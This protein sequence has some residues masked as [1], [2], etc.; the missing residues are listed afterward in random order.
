MQG[1]EEHLETVISAPLAL[2]GQPAF[3]LFYSHSPRLL[4]ATITNFYSGTLLEPRFVRPLTEPREEFRPRLTRRQDGREREELTQG[5]G[6]LDRAAHGVQTAP[7]ES[8]QDA[9]RKGKSRPD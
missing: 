3:N 4:P 7:G 2:S 6:W 8:R 5:V 1:Y 9:L